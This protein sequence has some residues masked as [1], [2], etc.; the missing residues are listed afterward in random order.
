[1]EIGVLT[2]AKWP[3]LFS[4]GDKNQTYRNEVGPTLALYLMSVNHTLP[5]EYE[6]NRQQGIF[7]GEKVGIGRAEA[8]EDETGRFFST[9]SSGW[10]FSLTK[11]G[12]VDR[13]GPCK[14]GRAVGRIR[15]S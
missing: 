15:A 14:T 11:M 7:I 3:A 10:I 1:M 13:F 6:E 5:T 9:I 8:F 2:H 12:W 4:K